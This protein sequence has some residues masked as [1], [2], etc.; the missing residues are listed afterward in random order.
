MYIRKTLTEIS[1][2]PSGPPESPI[3]AEASSSTVSEGSQE[4]IR[5]ASIDEHFLL[6]FVV[7]HNTAPL[8]RVIK[9]Q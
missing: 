1:C 7:R 5:L 2:Y 3:I 9:K 8:K 4:D 6:L